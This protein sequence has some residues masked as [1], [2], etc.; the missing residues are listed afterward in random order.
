MIGGDLRVEKYRFRARPQNMNF[1][2]FPFD[3]NSHQ[4]SLFSAIMF[5][6]TIC[7]GT[8]P[9][10]MYEEV[11]KCGIIEVLLIII[12]IMLLVQLSIH[13]YMR[14]WFYGT[15]YDYQHIWMCVFG[16]SLYQFIPIIL[17][18]LTYLTYCCR[19]SL[20]ICKNG[21]A[22]LTAVWPGCPS[23]LKSK[24]FLLYFI[25][26]IT[27]LPS[28]F[29]KSIV[30]LTWVAYLANIAKVSVIICL[31]ILLARS[32][33]E[34]GF[35]VVVNTYGKIENPSLPFFPF[36]TLF[37]KDPSALFIC[38]CSVMKAFFM[39]PMLGM[40]FSEM[41]NP[42]VYRCLSSA[43]LASFI[44]VIIY[45]GIGLIT[46]FIVQV[47]LQDAIQIESSIST[48]HDIHFNLFFLANSLFIAKFKNRNVFFNYNKNDHIEAIIGQISCYAVTLTSNI[49]YTHFIYTQVSSL[50]IDRKKDDV[51]PVFIS[52]VVVVLFAIGINF[53]VSQ[54]IDVLDMISLVSLVILEFFLPS[55][56]YLKLYRFTKPFWGIVCLV[57]LVIGIPISIASIYYKSLYIKSIL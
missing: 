21:A 31:I 29:V 10:L 11:F 26:A 19:F 17:N 47:H 43:W 32:V 8:G 54:V 5:I 16:S 2:L 30:S 53:M 20:E 55:F 3:R 13:V 4:I 49:I 24:W 7:M 37:S 35:N 42:T 56:F 45:Y 18:I 14:C 39:H 34:M 6:C 36:I 44:F 27:T 51:T 40:I 57:L 46:Y 22:F 9:F 23:F 48:K 15:A 33:H 52:G 12:V 38:V 28:L 25:N 41:S 50:I 1:V